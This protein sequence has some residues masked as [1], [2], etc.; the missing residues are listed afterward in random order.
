MRSWI[1]ICLLFFFLMLCINC[2]NLTLLF[3]RVMY[4]MCLG[5]EVTITEIQEYRISFNLVNL[6]LSCLRKR[7][8]MANPTDFQR[9]TNSRRKWKRDG[10]WAREGYR[11][12]QAEK[13]FF[14]QHCLCL[15]NV[16]SHLLVAIKFDLARRYNEKYCI[17]SDPVFFFLLLCYKTHGKWWKKKTGARFSWKWKKKTM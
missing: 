7:Y 9:H 16:F 3:G 11:L 13:V 10:K 2:F 8:K 4:A 15:F 1:T 5:T 12:R 17:N 6:F 14:S